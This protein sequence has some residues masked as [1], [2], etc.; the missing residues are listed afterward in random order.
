MNPFLRGSLY[1]YKEKTGLYM[2]SS[3]IWVMVRVKNE[4]WIV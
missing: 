4:H 1:P 3:L 2:E